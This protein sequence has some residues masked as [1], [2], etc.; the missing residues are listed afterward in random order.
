VIATYIQTRWQRDS[1]PVKAALIFSLEP[2]IA[3]ILAY[4]YISE[5]FGWREFMGGSIVLLG[6]LMGEIGENVYNTLRGKRNNKK[7]QADINH[8]LFCIHST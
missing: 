1:S 4:L 2:I 3:S 6:V 8:L 5:Q 7:E